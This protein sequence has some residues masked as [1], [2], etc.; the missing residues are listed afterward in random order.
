MDCAGQN[1]GAI[2][3]ARR[4]LRSAVQGDA[5]NG[6]GR[7]AESVRKG[8]MGN[9]HRFGATVAFLFTLFAVPAALAPAAGALHLTRASDLLELEL[10]PPDLTPYRCTP[11][12]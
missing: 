8:D 9:I 1:G 7:F 2:L 6:V 5:G 12:S 4:S 3:H 11:T 10:P